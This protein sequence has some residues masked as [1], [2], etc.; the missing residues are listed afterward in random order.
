MDVGCQFFFFA[1]ICL[2]LQYKIAVISQKGR[3]NLASGDTVIL[4]CVINN[5]DIIPG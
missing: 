4:G 2:F 3:F 1:L 5:P